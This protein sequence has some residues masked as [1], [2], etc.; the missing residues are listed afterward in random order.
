MGGLSSILSLALLFVILVVA[1]FWLLIYVGIRREKNHRVKLK[2]YPSLAIIIPTIT[3]GKTLLKA[4][5]SSLKIKY[6][7]NKY[8]IYVALNQSSTPET[9][10]AAMSVKRRN[11][12]VVKCPMDGKA[13]VMNYVLKKHAREDLLLVLDADT[14]IERHLPERMAA[15]FENRKIGCVVASVKV[16]NPKTFAE[17]MQKYEYLLS[18]LSRKALSSMMGLMVAHGAGSMFRMSAIR[19]VGYFDENNPTEDLEMGLRLLT[20]GYRIE[21][22]PVAV[23]YTVVPS[24]LRALFKQRK[25]WFSG[26]FFNLTKYRKELFSRKNLGLG[27]FIVP[28]VIFSIF[29]GI[30]VLLS[31]SY[32]LF[33]PAAV[34]ISQEYAILQNTN[35]AVTLNTQLAYIPD[36]IF[37]SLDTQYILTLFTVAIG[38]FS[39]AYSLKYS[40]VKIHKFKDTVGIIGYLAFYA[41]FLSFIWLYTS[42]VYIASRRTF[43]WKI[44]T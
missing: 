13:K 6:P 28:L 25:R 41:F 23:S 7:K 34:F 8:Y 39:L 30:F 32:S 42:V 38:L 20:R 16:L 29:I 2:G 37:F 11:V 40:G 36:F 24:T 22:S 3:E 4:I 12:K 1:V 10:K 18:I 9:V 19:K 43:T 5:N 31:L 15:Y 26:F 44:G 14:L 17:K 21:T 35:A 27:L 33:Y